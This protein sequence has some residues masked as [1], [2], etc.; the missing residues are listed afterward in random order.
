MIFFS[1]LDL[2]K[3]GAG[4]ERERF[5]LI[6]SIFH[7]IRFEKRKRRKKRRWGK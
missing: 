1:Q 2:K 6:V 4:A 7:A 3:E 5:Y